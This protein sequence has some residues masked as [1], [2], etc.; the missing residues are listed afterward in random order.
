MPK[1]SEHCIFRI[2]F[3]KRCRSSTRAHHVV[4]RRITETN[5]TETAE[6]C[7]SHHLLEEMQQYPSTSCFFSTDNRNQLDR[8]RQ[9]IVVHFNFLKRCSST[10]AHQFACF[11][12]RIT[13]TNLT[14][15]V[16][17]LYFSHH[18]LEELQQHPSTSF[19]MLSLGG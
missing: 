1:P 19:R 16:R 11:S 10:G 2:T 17:A 6:H 9:S 18:L 14:E 15:T 5:S 8:N 12:R 7:S 13:E 3:L 4:S